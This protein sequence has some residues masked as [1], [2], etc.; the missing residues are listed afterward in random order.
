MQGQARLHRWSTGY[1][2]GKSPITQK[3]AKLKFEHKVG[4]DE[5]LFKP[6]L[7]APGH[8]IKILQAENGQKVDKFEPIYL[9]NYRY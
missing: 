6:S 4:A 5:C 3:R 7:G 9:G 8:V 2:G 1:V